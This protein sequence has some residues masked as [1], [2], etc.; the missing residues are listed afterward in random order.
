MNKSIH[1]TLP[2]IAI[3]S[4]LALALLAATP[5]DAA[6][7]PIGKTYFVVSLGLATDSEE[8]YEVDFGCVRF[9]RSEICDQ[10]DECGS[11]WLIEGAEHAPRQSHF[12]FEFDVFDDE[13]GLPV[14]MTG[15]GRID[16]RGP[17]SSLAAVAMATEPTTGV[18]I[19]FALAGR[20]VGAPR[21]ARMVAEREAGDH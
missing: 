6:K 9:T 18:K 17:K 2:V 1:Q 12:A 19:N 15:T 4:A 16:S 5:A 7:P 8:S 13:T 3:V 20:A 10:G 14:S 11:W 21:C